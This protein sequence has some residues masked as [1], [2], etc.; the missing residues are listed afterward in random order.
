MSSINPISSQAARNFGTGT[1]HTA[2]PRGLSAVA[3]RLEQGAAPAAPATR[4]IILRAWDTV[5]GAFSKC[6]AWLKSWFCCNSASKVASLDDVIDN[7]QGVCDQS[8]VKKETVIAAFKELPQAVQ[9]QVKGAMWREAGSPMGNANFSDDA[10]NGGNTA[11]IKQGV[12]RFIGNRHLIAIRQ[13]ELDPTAPAEK[14]K[15]LVGDLDESTK[16]RIYGA[17]YAAKGSPANVGVNFGAEEFARNPKSDEVKTAIEAV[18][19]AHYVI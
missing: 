11:L 6:F 10:V 14:V 15:A 19:N 16:N 8:N 12:T 13:I 1:V 3:S 18:F 4:N 9:D 5:T 7:L 2:S 17:V